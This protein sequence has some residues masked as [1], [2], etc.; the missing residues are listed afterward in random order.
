MHNWPGIPVGQFQI[1]SGPF[2]AATDEFHVTITGKG[3]HAAKPHETIDPVVTASHVVL[4]LQSIASRNLDPVEQLVVSVTSVTTDSN[5][6]NVIP[7]K[8]VLRGTV[9]TLKPEVRDMAERRLS[10]I[11]AQVT[12]AFGA[13]AVIDYNRSYP[14]MVNH[15]DQTEFAAEVARAVSGNCG[16]APL[17]MG[18]EDFAYMLEACPGAY[19]LVGNGDTASVHHPEYDFTDETIP[20][21]CSWWAELIE[22]RLGSAA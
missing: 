13:R 1:R 17:V 5:A 16:E 6:H 7:N 11:C 20:A 15:A 4:A 19:I 18:G 2:F 8:V 12:A 10:E 3:G 14:V 22:R 21:G 9:R